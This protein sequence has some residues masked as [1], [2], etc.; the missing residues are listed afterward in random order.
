MREIAYSLCIIDLPADQKLTS[1]LISFL[2]LM[3]NDNQLI[4]QHL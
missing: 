2:E 3:R 1:Y 4:I